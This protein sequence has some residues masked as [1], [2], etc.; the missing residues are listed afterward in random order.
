F[1]VVTGADGSFAL[2]ALAPGAYIVYPMLGGGGNKPKDIY[3]KKVIVEMGKRARVDI[4][5]TAGPI[6][7]NVTVKTDKGNPVPMAGIATIGTA[8]DVKSAE[9]FQDLSRV[10]YGPD[11]VIPV[12]MRPALGGSV[13]LTGL[14]TGLHTVCA[15]FG[16]PMMADPS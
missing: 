1:F 9:E 5:T 15:I 7:L 3:T 6:T 16:N 12:Y 8:L 13:E 11:Q 14:R 2:D 4:D 10:P